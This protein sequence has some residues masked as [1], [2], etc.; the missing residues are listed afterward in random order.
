V[1][2]GITHARSLSCYPKLCSAHQNYNHHSNPSEIL[3][4][5]LG[6]V[7]SLVHDINQGSYPATSKPH[8]KTG[9]STVSRIPVNEKAPE[10]CVSGAFQATAE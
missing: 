10:T 5:R 6:N 4:C 2:A 9:A 7:P 1:A 3:N 8:Q